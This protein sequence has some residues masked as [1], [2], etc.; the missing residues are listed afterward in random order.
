MRALKVLLEI[1]LRYLNAKEYLNLMSR[2]RVLLQDATPEAVGLT[3]EEMAEFEKYVDELQQRVSFTTATLETGDL[4]E[5]ELQ[6]D[7][8]ITY[9][10][11]AI[12]NGKDLPLEDQA[13][14]AKALGLTIQPYKGIQS[15]PNQQETV[16]IAGLLLDWS[17]EEAKT[18]L[19]TMGLTAVVAK[20]Q[21]VNDNYRLLSAKRARDLEALTPATV[22]ELR[23]KL[24]PIF[25]AI[26]VITLAESVAKPTEVTAE[27]ILGFNSAIREVNRLNSLRKEKGSEDSEKQDPTI[28][29]TDTETPEN[30]DDQQPTTPGGEDQTGEEQQP[31]GEQTT[32]DPD[33][34]TPQPGVDNDGDG[35]PEVV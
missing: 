12:E 1:H 8:I 29:G 21:E 25:E 6:R 34:N 22:T 24:D 9:L 33:D 31:G 23:A 2:L 5:G 19:A 16:S 7:K 11:N 26:K 18:H 4:D 10:F 17:S 15:L 28:P 20:L 13:K 27:F 30:P 35:S 14:A 32:P 3:A